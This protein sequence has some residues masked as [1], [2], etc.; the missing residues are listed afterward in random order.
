MNP[1]NAGIARER[2][3]RHSG[4]PRAEGYSQETPSSVATKH[5]YTFTPRTLNHKPSGRSPAGRG[6]RD[7]DSRIYIIGENIVHQIFF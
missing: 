1:R 4:L 2:R 5:H 3:G 6:G 7:L